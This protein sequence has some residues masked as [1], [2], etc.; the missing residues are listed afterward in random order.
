LKRIIEEHSIVFVATVDNTVVGASYIKG[1][2]RR[3]GTAVYPEQYRR[4]GI[5]EKLVRESLRVIPRQY[6]ILRVTN[7]KMLSLMLKVGFKKA[8]S[9]Q[10]VEKIV[11]DE[12][13]QLSD[14]RFS[15]DCLIFSRYSAKR[16]TD[17]ENLTLLHTFF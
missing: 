14:F 6:T 11:Q 1:N 13:F 4:M 10:A 9:P 17:R 8:G 7:A 5:A 15:G 16:R 12:F 3:G 2:L